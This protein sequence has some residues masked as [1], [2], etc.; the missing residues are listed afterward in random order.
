MM[1]QKDFLVQHGGKLYRV[2]SGDP[3]GP[4]QP[5]A[6]V[7][8]AE[9]SDANGLERRSW[10]HALPSEPAEWQC[11]VSAETLLETV[12]GPRGVAECAGCNG[13]GEVECEYGYPHE[14]PECLGEKES[15]EW[16]PRWRRLG[17]VPVDG[18]LLADAIGDRSGIISIEYRPK[19]AG[20]AP[21]WSEESRTGGIFRLLQDGT[22]FA[23]IASGDTTSQYDHIRDLDV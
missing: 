2:T 16:R 15:E 4:A 19:G 20:D 22:P 1:E 5:Y 7:R 14:C 9:C 11:E 17:G 18:L 6:F 21:K 8:V 10:P 23:L 3:D 12:G 13:E